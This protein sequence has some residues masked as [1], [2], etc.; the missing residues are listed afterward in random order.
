VRPA[1]SRASLELEARDHPMEAIHEGASP[2]DEIAAAERHEARG[3]RA[4]NGRAS[5][6]HPPPPTTT[7]VRFC[8]DGFSPT[9]ELG[10]SWI[11]GAEG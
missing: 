11:R 10:Y 5:A 7:E 1:L 9:G 3:A 6:Q 4:G 2:A 8:R